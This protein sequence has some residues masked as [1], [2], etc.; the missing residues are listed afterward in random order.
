MNL[1]AVVPIRRKDI[2]E[3]KK[4]TELPPRFDLKPMNHKAACNW[5][6]SCRNEFTDYRLMEWPESEPFSC[7]PIIA[8]GYRRD[9]DKLTAR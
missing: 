7:K 2:G 8:D 1:Y 9:K 6:D 4:G 3:Q 5:M